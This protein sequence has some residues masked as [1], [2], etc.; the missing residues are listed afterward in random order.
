MVRENAVKKAKRRAQDR[1]GEKMS[2]PEEPDQA[3]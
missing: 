1:L 3:E 2:P